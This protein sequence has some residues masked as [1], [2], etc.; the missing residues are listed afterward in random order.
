MVLGNVLFGEIYLWGRGREDA[1]CGVYD[2]FC[3][4]LFKFSVKL[5]LDRG[6]FVFRI[7]VG[8]LVNRI[9]LSFSY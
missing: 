8:S 7:L 5:S 9:C 1:V 4:F 6:V 2:E 3:R